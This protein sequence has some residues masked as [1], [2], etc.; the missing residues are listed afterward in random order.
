[1]TSALVNKVQEMKP[2]TGIG[3]KFCQYSSVIKFFDFYF[4][5]LPVNRSTLNRTTL[6]TNKKLKRKLEIFLNELNLDSRASKCAQ[7]RLI[8]QISYLWFLKEIIS[9]K[10]NLDKTLHN[11]D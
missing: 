4:L 3:I 2:W 8:L 7:H 10:T 1:M 5:H 11:A 9:T 6:K